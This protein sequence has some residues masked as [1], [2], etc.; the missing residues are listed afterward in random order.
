MIDVFD[1]WW[2]DCGVLDAEEKAG[3]DAICQT[4]ILFFFHRRN[5]FFIR[6]GHATNPTRRQRMEH[7]VCDVRMCAMCVIG[8][9]VLV[10]P[11]F[12]VNC[13]HFAELANCACLFH[14]VSGPRQSPHIPGMHP[15]SLIVMWMSVWDGVWVDWAVCGWVAGMG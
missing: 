3:K 14:L 1:R 12:I 11:F 4:W 6:L 15:I 5:C 8:I 10:S 9:W 2:N 13:D 7:T